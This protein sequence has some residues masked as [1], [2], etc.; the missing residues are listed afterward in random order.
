MK[1]RQVMCD[2][3][4][5]AEA[6]YRHQVDARAF[7][8]DD[9]RRFDGW[10]ACRKCHVLIMGDNEKALAQRCATLRPDLAGYS[11]GL[12]QDVAM[13]HN[14]LFWLTDAGI[15]ERLENK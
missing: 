10:L 5:S 14:A 15:H 7:E 1:S 13:G 3:C 6:E 4:Q 12:A 8:A 11:H 9:E 2:F